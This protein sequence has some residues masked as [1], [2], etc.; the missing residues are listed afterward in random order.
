VPENRDAVVVGAGHNGLVAA[1]LLVDAGWDVLVLEATAHAGGAVRSAP[2][3]PAPGFTA[4]LYSAFYPLGAA[5]PVLRALDLEP[6][7]LRWTHA[8]DVL[9]HVFDDGRAA[10]LSRDLDRTAASLDEFAEGDGAAWRRQHDRWAEIED[11]VLA[12]LFTPFPPVRAGLRLA[13]RVGVGRGLRLARFGVLPVRRFVEEEFRGEG[14][15]LLVAGNA[16]HTDLAPESAGGALYGTLLAMVGQR[17]G[18]PVPAGGSGRMVDAL[19]S[20][21]VARGG[22]V[23]CGAPVERV[24]VHDGRASG[25]VTAAGERVLASRAVLADV[26]A[27]ILYDRLLADV[28]LP[29]RLRADLERFQWDAATVKVD[30]ALRAPVPW[31]SPGARGAGTVHLG[32]DLDGL[33]RYAADLATRRTPGRPF[34]LFGQMTTADPSRS[35]AGTESAWAYTHLPRRDWSAGEVA[36]AA[37]RIEAEVERQAPGFR[38]LVAGRLVQGPGDLESAE[39]GLVGGAVNGGTAAIHQQLVLRPTPGLG[40]ADTVVPGLFLAGSSAHPGGG[41]HGGC[42]AN[43][44]RAALAR[45]RVGRVVYDRAM[46]TLEDLLL[47]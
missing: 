33:T 34:T 6:H 10:V 32:A 14:A 31:T 21:L 35:P 1:N 29:A 23:R 41:V 13:R 3:T 30:W 8:P 4:D 19:V 17:F 9:A 43:A 45:A 44:A 40:R 16:L 11:S 5:S 27:P 18:F 20:R 39:P 46:G 15:H 36:A 42:G 25:V 2:D 47:R 28:P 24:Q 37:E 7:G 22:E 12:A 38:D 26:P